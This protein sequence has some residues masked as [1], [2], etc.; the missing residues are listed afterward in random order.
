MPVSA[1]GAAAL[2]PN[3]LS[4]SLGGAK[5]TLPPNPLRASLGATAA[6]VAS[7]APSSPLTA[8]ATRIAQNKIDPG[9]VQHLKTLSQA[10]PTFEGRLNAEIKKVTGQMEAKQNSGPLAFAGS[11]IEGAA[12]PLEWVK[13]AIEGV[14]QVG[15]GV[16]KAAKGN[17]AGG[18]EQA[19]LGALGVAGV[20]PFGRAAGVIGDA[21]KAGR[22]AEEASQ[23]VAEAAA[24][25]R[26][27]GFGQ[28]AAKKAAT[29]LIKP[30]D[31][32]PETGGE[33]GAQVRA[34]LKGSTAA[35]NEQAGLQSIERGKRFVDA[36]DAAQNETGVAAYQAAVGRL[37]GKLPQVDFQGF[38][39]LDGETLDA[40]LEHI[41]NHPAIQMGEKLHAQQSLMLAV[42]EGKV[43]T[44]G[45]QKILEK[46]FG[47]EVTQQIS[48][49]SS[50]FGKYK[51]LAL[52]AAN[53]PR[54]IMSSAD[55]SA[56]FRQ[57]LVA[58]VTHPKLFFKAF[59]PMV[60]S[61]GSERVFQE[62]M[63]SIYDDPIFPLAHKA[64]LAM[65][66]I[67]VP[68]SAVDLAGREESFQSNLAERLNLREVKVLHNLG[69]G[70]KLGTGPGDLIRASDRAYVMFL[71][72]I[73]FD[74]FKQLVHSAAVE[75]RDLNDDKLVKDIAKFVNS[76][77]G[78]G[79]LGAFQKHAATMNAIFFSPRLIMSRVNFLNPL[80]YMKLDPFA[81]KQAL[82]AAFN[83]VG[84]MGTILYLSKLAGAQVGTDPTSADFAKIKVG[85]TRIDIAGGF[86][87]YVRLIGELAE[88]KV[89]SST[90]GKP[91][92]L[93]GGI[94]KT[95]IGDIILRTFFSK[96]SPTVSFGLQASKV[97]QASFGPKQ[98]MRQMVE[99]R[100]VPL[101]I[102]DAN[103]LRTT[104]GALG[105][106][107]SVSK[108]LL[109]YG[110]GTFGIGEQ[111]YAPTTS[112][113][114]SSDTGGTGGYW[115]GTAGST[116][117]EGYWGP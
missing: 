115:G 72:K 43:P 16:A 99:Q 27:K 19:G 84:T 46:V 8:Y 85:N 15:H 62:G 17:L 94:G 116:G 104:P 112:T 23:H 103:D 18:A 78:R 40:M 108:S 10:D 29:L 75:N 57:G 44:A 54:A 21:V 33:L 89:T 74:V 63:H 92:K 41:K 73:R 77:T 91:M 25:A 12:N 36:A 31:V 35:R 80:Y 50:F 26:A 11:A 47:R 5:P 88:G 111:T 59:A 1:R 76:A 6:P 97:S 69:L 100:M 70:G 71:N 34:G 68:H 3:P 20:L 98:S 95:S 52:E 87:Q 106:K 107:P 30:G 109:G 105:G 90:T 79:D 93:S 66:D 7:Q 28:T 22:T 110:L 14:P 60:K 45:E 38:K 117:G 56:P 101:L 37:K 13:G 49:A 113:G 39:Q 83:L 51:H 65:T 81:R 114:S 86:Q 55:L 58:G 67:G 53:I 82:G 24:A 4:A 102:Q 64:Q 48:D 61:F 42:S 2:P 32:T 9:F 96:T